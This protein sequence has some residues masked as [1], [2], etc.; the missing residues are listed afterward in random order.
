MFRELYNG[1]RMPCYAR[2][3]GGPCHSLGLEMYI[4]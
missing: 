2:E 3:K 1:V 4:T